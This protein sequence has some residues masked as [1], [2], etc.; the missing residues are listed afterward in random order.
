MEKIKLAKK[1][2]KNLTTE[3][4]TIDASAYE[5][6][7]AGDGWC[8]GIDFTLSKANMVYLLKQRIN[9]DNLFKGMK[10]EE[11]DLDH[12]I[13]EA[14]KEAAWPDGGARASLISP[15]PNELDELAAKLEKLD[16]ND[17]EAV[18]AIREKLLKVAAGEYTFS[19]NIVTSDSF[20]LSEDVKE[21]ISLTAPQALGLLYNVRPSQKVFQGFEVE[22]VNEYTIENLAEQMGF[23]EDYDYYSY[24]GECVAMDNYI[25]AW[26]DLIEGILA[27]DIT[28]DNLDSW[29]EYFDNAGYYDS[30]F[31]DWSL[32]EDED[33]GEDEDENKE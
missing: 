12:E 16:M 28:E 20:Y 24:G 10:E 23:A 33:E 14:V 26:T 17:E 31:D 11:I 21:H 9:N 6:G 25:D 3:S 2:L 22:S 18:K 4:F 8:D 1:V 5:G 29:M 27:G 15:I 13:L 19:F 32:E 7:A 30:T